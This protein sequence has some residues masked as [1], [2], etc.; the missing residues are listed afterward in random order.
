MYEW[1]TYFGGNQ[2]AVIPRGTGDWLTGRWDSR[3]VLRHCH[4]TWEKTRLARDDID[5]SIFDTAIENQ[6]LFIENIQK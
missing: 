4:T 6:D 5:H 3:K 2:D 1:N